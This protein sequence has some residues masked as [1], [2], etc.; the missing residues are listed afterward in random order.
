MTVA[1]TLTRLFWSKGRRQFVELTVTDAAVRAKITEY[2]AKSK[3]VNLAAAGY[4]EPFHHKVGSDWVGMWRVTSMG[5]NLIVAHLDG[6]I[7]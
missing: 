7:A 6:G 1:S 3:L 4:V 5:R 2:Q